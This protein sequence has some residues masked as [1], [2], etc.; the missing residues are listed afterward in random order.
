MKKERG[1][2]NFL[3]RNDT[4]VFHN[5]IHGIFL[6]TPLF[7]H[8]KFLSNPYEKIDV[9][10]PLVAASRREGPLTHSQNS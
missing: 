2:E 4:Q 10:N 3:F 6:P 7:L 9:T 8:I 1:M 5:S